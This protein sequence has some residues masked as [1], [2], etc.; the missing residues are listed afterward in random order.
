MSQL[1]IPRGA[2]QLS[3]KVLGL[4]PKNITEITLVLVDF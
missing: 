3:Y 2:N 1:K 4:V